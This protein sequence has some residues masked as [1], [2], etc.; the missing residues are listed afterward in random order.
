MQNRDTAYWLHNPY[1]FMISKWGRIKEA[2]QT[3]LSWGAEN[4][5][6]VKSGYPTSTIWGIQQLS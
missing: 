3:L 5:G 6:G 4:R 2:T 1:Y